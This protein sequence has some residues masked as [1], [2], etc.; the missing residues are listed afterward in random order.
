MSQP[1]RQDFSDKVHNAVKPDSQKTFTEH[2]GDMAQGKADSGLSTLQP[3]QDKS[4]G[5]KAG[6]ALSGQHNH[7]PGER[8][9]MDK[10]KDAVGLG[11]K[12]STNH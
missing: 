4:M 11:D 7:N 9:L 2:I 5:Q 10:A 12:T 1:G 8:S 6:D 3:Q